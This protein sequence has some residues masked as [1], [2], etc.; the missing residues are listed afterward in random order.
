MNTSSAAAGSWR[1][2]TA[3][4]AGP[5]SATRARSRR[6]STDDRGGEPGPQ[7]LDV[8]LLAAGVDDEGQVIV[9]VV[10]DHHVVDD[11]TV[12]GGQ[13]RVAHAPDAEAA[14]RGGHQ[15]FE[16]RRHARPVELD[17]AH[18]ADVEERGGRAALLVLGDGPRTVADRHLVAGE[19]HHPTPVLQVE[20]VQAGP[21]QVVVRA[22]GSSAHGVGAA[23]CPLC[24]RY[25]RVSRPGG[26]RRRCDD[27]PVPL[28]PSVRA[29]ALLS[30]V[31]RT[32]RS[33]LPERFRGGCSFGGPS[34]RRGA[35]RSPAAFDRHP[36]LSIRIGARRSST[37]G[38]RQQP[39]RV[40]SA[41]GVSSGATPQLV[42]EIGVDVGG[43]RAGG[44][45]R[46][47]G[48]AGYPSARS[49]WRRGWR[50]AG[51][52]TAPPGVAA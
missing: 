1:A 14:D 49:R 2:T 40:G 25:L 17:D 5:C 12:L 18:V 51:R 24:H 45:R 47:P 35:G 42:P 8:G 29:E 33:R 41:G 52:R 28:T 6:C 43:D 15:P 13:H 19:R 27:R 48:P 11:A 21:V 3:A 16:R 31:A 37:A 9:A 44:E 39:E 50:S 20:G 34:P 36:S 22:Q 38:D 7:V 4:A 46:R 30:R 23:G 10:G 32:P 26:R